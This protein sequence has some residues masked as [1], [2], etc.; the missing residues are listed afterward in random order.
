MTCGEETSR[1]LSGVSSHWHCGTAAERLQ[2]AEV[3]P[4]VTDLPDLQSA[5]LHNVLLSPEPHV[6]NKG[7]IS[8]AKTKAY[9]S[10]T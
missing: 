9:F 10:A 6:M 4:M 5:R 2:K 3:P 8:L 1:L 7:S